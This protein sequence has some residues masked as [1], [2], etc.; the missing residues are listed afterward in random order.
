MDRIDALRMLIDVSE[1]GTFSAVAR[2]RTIATST[3]AVAINQLEQETG[4][5]LMTRSTR[6]LTFTPEGEALL[7]E[8]RRIV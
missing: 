8:A 4:A 6:R 1:T 2:Q 7:E 5:R 3:V